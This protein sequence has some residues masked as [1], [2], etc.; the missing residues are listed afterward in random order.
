MRCVFS[1]VLNAFIVIKQP[2]QYDSRN[3]GELEL[4]KRSPEIP[5]QLR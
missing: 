1:V 2:A 5:P 4:Q 3:S